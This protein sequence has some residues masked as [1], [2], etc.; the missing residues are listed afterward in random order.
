MTKRA[1]SPAVI[2]ALLLFGAGALDTPALAGAAC[3]AGERPLNFGF[4]AFFAPLSYSADEDPDSPGFNTHLGF[5]ADLVSAL[6]AMP[7][8]GLT[9]TRRPIAEWDDIWLRPAGPRYDLV[10]G[11]ITILESRTRDPAG[12]RK[13]AFTAGHIAFRQSLLVRA[14]DAQRLARYDALGGEVRVGAL[15]A[16]T[17]EARLLQLTGLADRAGI[18][19]AG[20]RVDTPRGR[21]TA[22]GSPDY[23]ITAAAE[24][25]GLAGRRHLHPPSGRMP[26]VIYLGDSGGE[27]ELLE[28][29]ARRRIDAIARGEIGNR[30]AAR[31]SDGAFAVTAIDAEHELGGFALAVEDAALRACLDEKID[32]LTDH[33]RIG[34][35]AWLEDPEVFMRRAVQWRAE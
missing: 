3:T 19:A 30:A 8:A 14:E 31:A 5:E 22:D 12:W 1:V 6:E 4:Y 25:P 35:A 9:F 18:L 7:G 29:L 13:I 28:A 16:T 34:Y 2:T 17:G 33:R 32:Y 21:V 23:F 24:S 10:G 11:G 27:A 15:A 20:V 26:Q